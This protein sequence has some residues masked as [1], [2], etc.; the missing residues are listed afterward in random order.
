MGQTGSIAPTISVFNIARDGIL[1][2]NFAD[3]TTLPLGLS[4]SQL[5]ISSKSKLAFLD[6]FTPPPL[7][8]VTGANQILPFA[9]GADGALV[10]V[11]SG[12]IGAPVTPP[13]LLGLV[14]NPNANIIYGSLVG[15]AKIGVFTY[16]NAGNVKLADIVDVGLKGGGPCWSVISADGKYLYSAD[17]GSNSVGV[18]SL[19]NPLY[20]KQIQEFV[21]GGPQNSANSPTAKR[22][23]TDFELALD[24]G[25]KSLYVIDHQNDAA[26]DF[27]QGNALHV[28][29]VA[30]DGK[31]SESANS[32]Q[33][34]PSNIPAGDAPQGVAVI[35]AS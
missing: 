33:F 4:P 1:T 7:N 27:P 16:D 14:Q 29:S 23:T 9:I 26:G 18:Y 32:T 19:A 25:G 30:S 28:L 2:Q 35:A 10:P 24:P 12:G 15:A 21:L 13:L 20:P 22:E 31:V 3:T 34:L 6:T 11:A 17:T 8:N 5:L